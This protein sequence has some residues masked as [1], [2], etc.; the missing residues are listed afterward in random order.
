MI[1]PQAPLKLLETLRYPK[2]DSSLNDKLLH[3]NRV[4]YHFLDKNNRGSKDNATIFTPNN[5]ILKFRGSNLAETCQKSEAASPELYDSTLD[6]FSSLDKSIDSINIPNNAGALSPRINSRNFNQSKTGSSIIKSP[7]ARETAP[8]SKR[9][10][11]DAKKE[12]NRILSE[13]RRV[14]GKSH[15]ELSEQMEQLK[16]DLGIQVLKQKMHQVKLKE[17]ACK[18][19]VMEDNLPNILRTVYQ[20]D[21]TRVQDQSLDEMMVLRAFEARKVDTR[22]F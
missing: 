17:T 1:Y 15:G 20:E 11:S 3:N 12:L 8:A 9:Y 21:K 18:I 7:K 4:F 5:Q 13:C 22:Y 14:K 10:E 2:N 19:Q 6:R 16:I